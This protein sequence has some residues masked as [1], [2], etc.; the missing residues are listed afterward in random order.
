[1]V[2]KIK[3]SKCPSCQKH[4]ITAFFKSGRYTHKLTC[5]Y[6][7]KK[8][9]INIALNTF[10]NIGVALSVGLI[11]VFVN[12]YIIPMPLWFWGIVAVVLLGCFQYFAPLEEIE[13]PTSRSKEQNGQEQLQASNPA[14]V[15]Y[16]K[17][18]SHAL[19]KHYGR[20]EVVKYFD[21]KNGEKHI[22]TL[23]FID[24]N[25]KLDLASIVTYD[26]GVSLNLIP[27]IK[28][29]QIPSDYSVKSTVSNHTITLFISDDQIN[30]YDYKDVIE[31]SYNNL[32]CW[33][34]IK[35]I[36][37]STDPS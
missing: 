5:K 29:V 32:K 6:C 21:V 1:M 15:E 9:K 3:C 24:A 23:C 36:N 26:G 4:G 2:D 14:L 16:E 7:S 34:G 35:A 30:G 19:L 33:I 12:D 10:V 13:E 8:F 11:A 20:A 37:N 18:L 28:D 27:L 22:D 25:E 31:F 17:K